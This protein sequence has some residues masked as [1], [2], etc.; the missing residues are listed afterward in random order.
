MPMSN[1]VAYATLGHL[2]ELL[3]GHLEL[4]LTKGRNSRPSHRKRFA[5]SL[6]VSTGEILGL[7]GLER[8]SAGRSSSF[9]ERSCSGPQ[10]HVDLLLNLRFIELVHDVVHR[11]RKAL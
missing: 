3:N 6:S 1:L 2:L 11:R 9:A 8:E 10:R 4:S 5:A 7:L